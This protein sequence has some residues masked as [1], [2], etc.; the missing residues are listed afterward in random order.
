MY[1]INCVTNW[2]RNGIQII[3]LISKVRRCA[4]KEIIQNILEP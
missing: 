4:N 2:F 1:S 3:G